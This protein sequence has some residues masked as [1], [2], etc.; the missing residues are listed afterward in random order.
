[1]PDQVGLGDLLPRSAACDECG[2]RD[3][4]TAPVFSA[5]LPAA[6]APSL[7]RALLL[8]PLLILAGCEDDRLAH[9]NVSAVLPAESASVA[10]ASARVTDRFATPSGELAVIPIEHAAL[11][12]GWQG[13]A[14]YVDPI[15]PEIYDR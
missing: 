13:K 1:M 6:V 8:A 3:P 5:S 12:F 11:I 14:F 9:Q 4:R 15:G 2:V 7:R 10:F